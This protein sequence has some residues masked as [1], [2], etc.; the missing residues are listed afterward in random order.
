MNKFQKV[1]YKIAKTEYANGLIE[2][3]N[4]SISKHNMMYGT[5]LKQKTLKSTQNTLYNFIKR[6]NIDIHS[7]YNMLHD[8][9][10][11]INLDVELTKEYL[12]LKIDE[13]IE[14]K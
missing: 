14:Y 8:S 4:K 1:A 10:K 3:Q 13:M 2:L 11:F 12:K 9:R 7:A 6:D 5:K